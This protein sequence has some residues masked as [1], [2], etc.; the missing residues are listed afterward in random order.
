MF[1]E[2]HQIIFEMHKIFPELHQMFFC[3]AENI[4]KYYAQNI[5]RIHYIFHENCTK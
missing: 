5:P 2:L 3:N 4:S 1:P